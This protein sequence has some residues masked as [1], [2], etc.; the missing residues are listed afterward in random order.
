MMK[1]SR[2]VT[3]QRL[4]R[5]MRIAARLRQ[6]RL[7]RSAMLPLLLCVAS[8]S[9]AAQQ[10]HPVAELLPGGT[11]ATYTAGSSALTSTQ[12]MRATSLAPDTRNGQRFTVNFDVNSA[13]IRLNHE[14]RNCAATSYPILSASLF[15]TFEL[16]QLNN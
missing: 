16:Q 11:T 8:I 6:M 2:H 5:A 14:R 9:A 12:Q 13:A 10:R 7:R 3:P 15:V 4:R 1:Q